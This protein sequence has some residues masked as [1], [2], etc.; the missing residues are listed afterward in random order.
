MAA[1]RDNERRRAAPAGAGRPATVELMAGFAFDG[2]EN[3]TANACVV[4]SATVPLRGGQ[5]RCCAKR[6]RRHVAEGGRGSGAVR[7]GERSRVTANVNDGLREPANWLG[8]RPRPTAR[9][10][11]DARERRDCAGGGGAGG[12]GGGFAAASTTTRG[13]EALR[14]DTIGAKLGLTTRSW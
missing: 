11:I 14:R 3:L 8:P 10:R 9:E 7:S 4:Q 6:Q 13:S 12:R 1:K 2:G 5:C